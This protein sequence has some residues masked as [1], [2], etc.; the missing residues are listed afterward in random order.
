MKAIRIVSPGSFC[1][2]ESCADYGQ[3][4][5]GN[6]VKYGRTA[7]G[8]QRLK[9]KTCGH[10]FVENKG[11]IF[12]GC[13]HSQKTILDMLS[14]LAERNSLTSIHRVFGIKEE[15]VMEWLRKAADHVQ[16]VEDML[17]TGYHLDRVQLDAMWGYVW[18]KGEKANI[19]KRTTGALS[20]EAQ[21]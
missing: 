9:C 14:L 4:D 21:Q 7:K 6:L 15:T 18:H 8:T 3:L 10:V 12:Y 16:E 1:W 13:H 11:T 2:N 17:L 20:G 5:L 19:S